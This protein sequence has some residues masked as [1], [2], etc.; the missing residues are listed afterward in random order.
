MHE[1][2][3]FGFVFWYQNCISF[4]TFLSWRGKWKKHFSV[5]ILAFSEHFLK[6]PFKMGKFPFDITAIEHQI[7]VKY[8]GKFKADPSFSLTK[9]FNQK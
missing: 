8:P 3:V 2:Y 1:L 6:P 5:D 9:G 4:G 7:A